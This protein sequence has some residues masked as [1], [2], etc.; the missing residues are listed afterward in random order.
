MAV[1]ALTSIAGAPGVTTAAIAWAYQGP[2]PTLI[3][4]ADVTG[5]P[6]IVPTVWKGQKVEDVSVLDLAS[7]EPGAYAAYLWEHSLLLPETTDRWVLPTISSP[8]AAGSLAAVWTPLADALATISATAG[9]DIVIDAGRIGTPGGPWTLIE[10]ADAVL[11][12]TDST[13][14]ALARTQIG[15]AELRDALA[16]TGSRDRIAVVPVLERKLKTGEQL[17]PYS[18]RE[19]QSIFEPT[20]TVPGLPR[21]E[22]AATRPEP[23]KSAL[24]RTEPSPGQGSTS[25]YGQAI[26]ALVASAQATAAATRALLG[27]NDAATN[28]GVGEQW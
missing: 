16:H 14:A 10:R 13:L 23:R 2:R 3:I 26:R 7:R 4:E 15:V 25:S 1:Y 28:G 11:V 8:A 21:D 22:K 17:R 27:F 5:G 9:V 18:G 24:S 19:I 12:F 20:R 6:S